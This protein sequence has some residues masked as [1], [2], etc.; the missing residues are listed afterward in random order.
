VSTA[1]HDSVSAGSTTKRGGVRESWRRLWSQRWFKVVTWCVLA[2]VLLVLP[3]HLGN[4]WLRVLVQA[5]FG[6]MVGLGLN[7]MAG[8][9]GLLNL[10]YAA[11][12][13]VGA[14]TYAINAS[15]MRGVH[16]SFWLLFPLAGILAG[17]LGGLLALP[18]LSLR[19]DYLALVTLAFGEITRLMV[20]NLTITGAAQG[21]VG[22]DRPNLGF[23]KLRT[24]ADFYYF[25]LVVCVVLVIL[26]KRLEQSRLGLAWNAIREDEGAAK[27]MGVN[28]NRMKLLACILGAIPGGLAGVLFAGIQTYIS[29]VSFTMDESI[30]MLSM[31]LVGG[32]GSVP[33]VILGALLLNILPEPLREYAEA[34]RML[35]YGGLLVIFAIFRPQG[36]WPRSHKVQQQESTPKVTEGKA[37]RVLAPSQEVADQ[38]E[39]K[40]QP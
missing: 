19:G 23:A 14:Y 8:Y 10:G 13:A 5:G 29:P 31:V 26:V 3:K 18:V 38:S 36:I 34:Y 11:F 21:I 39:K 20:N 24:P 4:F 37:D 7:I 40:E 27:A 16:H 15:Q 28:T 2:V 1:D 33:G 17:V 30:F 32:L 35:V 25:T 12:Y 6:I 22:I 9:T